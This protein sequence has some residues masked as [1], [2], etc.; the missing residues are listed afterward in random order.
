MY[1]EIKN[2]ATTQFCWHYFLLTTTYIYINQQ[3]MFRNKIDKDMFRIHHPDFV[4][5]INVVFNIEYVLLHIH[6]I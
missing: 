3:I 6:F 5:N 4:L 2:P 1:L